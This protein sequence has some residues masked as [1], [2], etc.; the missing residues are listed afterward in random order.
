MAFYLVFIFLKFIFERF[1]LISFKSFNIYYC[2]KTKP[3][4]NKC[5]TF[6][7]SYNLRYTLQKRRQRS[8]ILQHFCKDFIR[9]YGLAHNEDS[10]DDA[11]ISRRLNSWNCK[12]F[13]HPQIGISEFAET[14]LANV[15][16]LEDNMKILE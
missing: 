16:Y 12:F 8:S 11:S 14:I 10:Y 13:Q 9:P 15:K 3:I 4:F 6:I 2:N 1:G 7:T 5:L